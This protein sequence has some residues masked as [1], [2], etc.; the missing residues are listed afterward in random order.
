[1]KKIY[2]LF[3]LFLLL[4]TG[5]TKYTKEDAIKDF[6]KNVTS[7]KSYKIN[8]TMEIN[9]G[10]ETFTYNIETYFLKDDYYKVILVNQTS[11]LYEQHVLIF[12]ND[13]I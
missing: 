12:Y 1:M 10:E 9:N 4:I 13:P 7:S 8:G 6:S 11:N 2:F 3:I 5:C